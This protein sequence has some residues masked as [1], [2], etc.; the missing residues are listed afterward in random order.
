ALRL[1]DAPLDLL[2]PGGLD[3]LRRAL[4]AARELGLEQ[5]EQLEPLLG[6]ELAC[7]LDDGANAV[8]H[9]GEPITEPR[10]CPSPPS[11]RAAVR[12]PRGCRTAPAAAG[13]GRGRDRRSER[14]RERRAGSPR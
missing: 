9:V 8:V 13:R 11:P 12:S 2:Q 7:L 1:G 5:V 4:A 14:Q 3:L 10:R 6:R